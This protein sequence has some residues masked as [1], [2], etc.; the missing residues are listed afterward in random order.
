L[1]RE[2]DICGSDLEIGIEGEVLP[3]TT[4]QAASPMEFDE[5]EAMKGTDLTDAELEAEFETFWKQCPRAVSYG[6]AQKIYCRFVRDGKATPRELLKGMMIYAAAREGEDERYT[7]TPARWLENMCWRDN[8]E[9]ISPKSVFRRLKERLYGAGAGPIYGAEP[10][11]SRPD[12]ADQQRHQEEVELQRKARRRREI[13]ECKDRIRKGGYK[14]GPHW[15]VP[16]IY[17]EAVAELQAENPP[18]V[19]QSA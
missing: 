4:E 14:S 12:P 5:A 7:Q 11:S 13:D 10:T 15:F 17:Q 2:K 1:N 9:A 6:K 16:D 3:P 19:K 8:P 18:A